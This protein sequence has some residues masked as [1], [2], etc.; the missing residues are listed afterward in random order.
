MHPQFRNCRN[1]G[2][3]KPGVYHVE[4]APGDPALVMSRSQLIEFARCPHRW[5][6]GYKNEG[7]KSK[8]FGSLIDCLV[9]TPQFFDSTFTIRP[10]EYPSEEGSKTK[11]FNT[12]MKPWSGNSTW[13]K[14]WLALNQDNQVVKS[15]DVE[16]MRVLADRLGNDFFDILA[17]SDRQVMLTADWTDDTTG[18]VV[19]I[20]CLIDLV[21]QRQHRKSLFDF[22]TMACAH[23]VVQAKKFFEFGYH[24]QAALELD[25]WNATH[26]NDPREDFRLFGVENVSPYE[27]FR[28]LLSE[29]FIVLGRS[30]YQRALHQ[31]AQCLRTNAWPGYDALTQ[32]NFMGWPVVEPA[33]WMMTQFIDN[34]MEVE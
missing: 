9:L 31:Y 30:V 25:M 21:P 29:E 14:E 19:P 5:R 32:R 26:P 22:K 11:G 20:K 13:C 12:V 10:D 28:A 34:E 18:A 27:P 4:Q 7:S 3:V 33:P 16:A 24:V 17:G 8:D 6:A 1:H 15:G 2:T 23:P